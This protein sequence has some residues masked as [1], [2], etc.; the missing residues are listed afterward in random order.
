LRIEW[1]LPEKAAC[2]KGSAKLSF[3]WDIL[4]VVL[5]AKKE[6]VPWNTKP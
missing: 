5:S 2:P 4:T 1:T 3:A 6:H